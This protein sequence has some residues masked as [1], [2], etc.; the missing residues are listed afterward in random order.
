MTQPVQ[1]K[2]LHA[3]SG[4]ALGIG[5]GQK[6]FGKA[7]DEVVQHRYGHEHAVEVE[8]VQC[9]DLN[10]GIGVTADA[11][12]ANKA[13]FLCLHHR[14]QDT[15]FGEA[16]VKVLEAFDVVHPPL[17]YVVGLQSVQAFFQLTPGTVPGPVHRLG[18]DPH[19]LASIL[20][21]FAHSF[22]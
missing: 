12:V 10:L 15:G 19:L 3:D 18:H 2:D 16:A 22:L 17:V 14:F 13:L 5:N 9:F 7:V 20:C 6:L 21:H 11:D 8:P 1:R 4:H